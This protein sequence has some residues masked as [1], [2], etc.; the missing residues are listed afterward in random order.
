MDEYGLAELEALSENRNAPVLFSTDNVGQVAKNYGHP[1]EKGGVRGGHEDGGH[2][3]V[4][5]KRGVRRSSRN[6]RDSRDSRDTAHP[7]SLDPDPKS[8]GER[9]EPARDDQQLLDAT[10][11]PGDGAV[12][13]LSGPSGRSDLDHQVRQQNLKHAAFR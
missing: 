5:L 10:P 12:R 2:A 7:F 8:R 11:P 9:G 6:S 3:S 1:V 4:R 13:C